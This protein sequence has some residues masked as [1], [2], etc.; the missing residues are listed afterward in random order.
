MVWISLKWVVS[1]W[2]YYMFNI[3]FNFFLNICKLEASKW[4]LK[5]ILI[6]AKSY[7]DFT[8]IT[9]TKN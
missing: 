9:I 1:V 5:T 6:D 8:T 2:I 3:D 4:I 7:E